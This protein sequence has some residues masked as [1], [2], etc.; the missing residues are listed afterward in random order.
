MISILSDGPSHNLIDKKVLDDLNLVQI[1][2]RIC[3]DGK[4]VTY[5]ISVLTKLSQDISEVEERQK[6]INDFIT[7]DGLMEYLDKWINNFENAANE[8]KT[9]GIKAYNNT[10][11]ERKERLA[12][13]IHDFSIVNKRL[14]NCLRLYTNLDHYLSECTFLSHGLCSLKSYIS[15]TINN[16]AAQQMGEMLNDLLLFG[17]NTSGVSCNI[18]LDYNTMDLETYIAD[19][20]NLESIK[21]TEHNKKYK[22]SKIEFGQNFYYD[23]SNVY[24]SFLYELLTTAVYDLSRYWY[25]VLNSLES[26]LLKLKQELQFYKFTLR[27]IEFLENNHIKYSYPKMI[28]HNGKTNIKHIKSLELIT[29]GMINIVP[30]DICLEKLNVIIGENN[31]GKTVFLRTLAFTQIF[32]QAGLPVP[33]DEGEIALVSNV[34]THFATGEKTLGRFEEEVADIAKIFDNIKPN[35]LILL[36][37]TFQSTSYKEIAEPFKDI[38]DALNSVNVKTALVTHNHD[39]IDM[40]KGANE[41]RLLR[42]ENYCYENVKSLSNNIRYN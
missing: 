30:Y 17:S 8:N 29:R 3:P 25:A 19:I 39:L 27:Y 15:N 40:Y 5:V 12:L 33:A 32:A 26:P 13:C 14:L 36:N 23:I 4:M 22:S 37:E 21:K 20:I 35:S 38:L 41:V 7:N 1:L 9:I 34:F 10:N 6:I 18:I 16:K 24:N 2:N 42:F 28:K 31:S 11:F